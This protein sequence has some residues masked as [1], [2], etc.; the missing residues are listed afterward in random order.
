MGWEGGELG[1]SPVTS[2]VILGKTPPWRDPHLW[3]ERYSGY[4]TS[5][6]YPFLM[7]TTLTNPSFGELS[8]LHNTGFWWGCPSECPALLST[9]INS[10]QPGQATA[11]N[12]LQTRGRWGTK[13][14]RAEPSRGHGRQ[15]P[16]VILRLP[17]FPKAYFREWCQYPSNKYFSSL[18]LS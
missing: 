4:L 18:K 9:G 15:M 14:V 7:V 1:F 2:D 11:D 5:I 6:F 8:L 17:G 10:T 16:Q 3:D 13:R 12:L